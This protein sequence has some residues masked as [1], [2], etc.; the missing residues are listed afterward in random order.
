MN[1]IHSEDFINKI[2]DFNNSFENKHQNLQ[3]NLQIS[4]N[5]QIN[6]P[7]AFNKIYTNQNTILYIKLFKDKLENFI[8]F[9]NS[10]IATKEFKIKEIEEKI[11]GC[12][13]NII[14]H[15]N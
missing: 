12:L 1:Q 13:N 8:T 5:N 7:P 3:I 15:Y 9:Y 6:I 10:S 4:G 2:K 11:K 14:V